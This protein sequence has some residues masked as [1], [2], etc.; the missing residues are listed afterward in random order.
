VPK[1]EITINYTIHI[2]IKISTSF[3]LSLFDSIILAIS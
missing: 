2:L 1:P 3:F